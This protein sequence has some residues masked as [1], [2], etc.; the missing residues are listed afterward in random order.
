MI[1]RPITKGGVMIGST[2]K[3]R[4]VP[5][6]RNPVRATMSAQARPSPRRTSGD[7]KREKEAVPRDAATQTRCNAVEAPDRVAEEPFEEIKWRKPAGII[8]ERTRQHLPDRE[9]HKAISAMISP[10]ADTV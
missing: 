4:S 3:A 1:A 8:F 10:S 7:R 5:L 9:E 2:V 6:K